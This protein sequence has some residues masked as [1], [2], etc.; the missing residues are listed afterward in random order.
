MNKKSYMEPATRVVKVQ[1]V[2]MIASSAG[3]NTVSGNTNLQYGGG[4]N[5]AALSRD[6]GW[7]EDDE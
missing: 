4:S 7:D 5:G 2:S 3:V 1:M 6:G